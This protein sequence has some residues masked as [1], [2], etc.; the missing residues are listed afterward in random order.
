M[1]PLD[2]LASRIPYL[3]SVTLQVGLLSRTA[4][5][6]D[7]LDS[8]ELSNLF[9]RNYDRLILA[10]NQ[11]LLMEY[12]GLTLA[13]DVQKMLPTDVQSVM[14]AG[15]GAGSSAK[16]APGAATDSDGAYVDVQQ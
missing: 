7:K 3:S 14:Q 16:R 10:R 8:E 6:R 1:T 2:P 12:H 11:P 15:A 13:L 5:P 4:A 9:K